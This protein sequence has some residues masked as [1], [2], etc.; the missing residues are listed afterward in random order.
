VL[1][2]AGEI[3]AMRIWGCIPPPNS[4][5]TMTITMYAD[6]GGAP[7][8][9]LNTMVGT[10]TVATV[11]SGNYSYTVSLPSP[12][13]VN[14]NTKYWIGMRGNGF[15]PGLKTV[16]NLGGNNAMARFNFGNPGGM[17]VLDDQAFVLYGPSGPVDNTPPVIVANVSGTQVNAPWYTS[18][19]EVTWSVSD[20]ETSIEASTGCGASSVTSDTD[21]VTFTCKATN[22]AGLSNTQSVTVMRDAS[23]PVITPSVVGTLGNNGWYTSDV[24]V[25]FTTTDPTSG[26]ASSSGCAASTVTADDAGTTYHCSASN[27]AGLEADVSVTVKRDGTA[28]SVSINGATSY[29]VAQTVT[30]SCTI[31]D[32]LSGIASQSCTSVNAPAYTFALGSHPVSASATDNAGNSASASGAFTVTVSNATLCELVRQFVSQAGIQNSLCKKL[33]NAKKD[34]KAFINE[35]EAQAGKH[36]PADK[37][38]ILIALARSLE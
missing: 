21:G 37:A 2:T 35:V 20:P 30:V 15:E 33:E 32:N 1:A 17:H 16:Q 13:S 22:A 19:V 4:G 23:A 12:I 10:P 38:S 3:H 27:G 8:A 5:V 26:V 14:A 11:A 24:S 25:S 7:G 29:T 18:D 34:L 9:V 6:A 31:N 36:V 28:P